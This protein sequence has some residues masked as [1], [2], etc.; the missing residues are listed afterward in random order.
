[1]DFLGPLA[2]KITFAANGPVDG[3]WTAYSPKNELEVTNMLND[4]AFANQLLALQ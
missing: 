2:G 1:M 3:V 4:T